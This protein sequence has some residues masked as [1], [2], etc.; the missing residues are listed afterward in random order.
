MSDTTQITAIQS[1][2]LAHCAGAE[3]PLVQAMLRLVL[4]DFLRATN[5]WR[6]RIEITP[7][8]DVA[9]YTIPPPAVNVGVAT[10]HAA[11]YGERMISAQSTARMPVG[12]VGEPR[13]VELRTPFE[14]QLYPPPPTEQEVKALILDVAWGYFPTDVR[15]VAFEM[16]RELVSHVDALMD[17][18][19]AR[20]YAMVDRPWASRAQS[21]IHARR[22]RAAVINARVGANRAWAAQPSEGPDFRFPPFA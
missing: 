22:Y 3:L 15:P 19:L 18:V 17:G 14:L 7:L 9:V 13:I 12:L 10:I 16:P 2:V 6:D 21:F 8:V 1:N 20:M 4:G 5:V 11:F